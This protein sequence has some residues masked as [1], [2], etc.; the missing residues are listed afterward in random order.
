MR[1][2]SGPLPSGSG[3]FR[4][5]GSAGRAA[6]PDRMQHR[7]RTLLPALGLALGLV[8]TPLAGCSSSDDAAART[9]GSHVTAGEAKVLA[10]L[11]HRNFEKGGA[12]FSETAPYADGAVLTLSGTVDFLNSTGHAEAVT[13]FDDGRPKDTRTVF[14]TTKEIWF[15]GVPG[16]SQAL[17]G[18]GLPDAQYVRR[19]LAA[20]ASNGQAQLVDVLAQLVLN[21][22]AR[23]SDDPKSFEKGNYAWQGQRAIDGRLASDYTLN[24][25]AKVAVSSD[26]L[27]LQYVTRLPDQDFAV[28]IT[29]PQHGRRT[30]DLPADT[31]TVNAADHPEVAAAVG[32]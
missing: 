25:G 31:A 28:T 15:G 27:L 21:L 20:V 9:P 10:D 6:Y 26:K 23:S 1:L 14:F 30:I 5:C 3:P 32:V 22:S 29:L 11:L 17:T 4:V 24:G 16:L 18:A 7:S 19:P 8:I 13:T 12:T 2:P